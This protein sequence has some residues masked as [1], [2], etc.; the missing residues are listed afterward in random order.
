MA[1]GLNRVELI[2]NVGREPEIRYTKDGKEIASFSLATTDVW[3]DK[4]SGEKKEKTEW[5]RIAVFYEGLV[6]LV[7]NY[8]HKGTRLYIN[9]SLHTRKWTDPN[10]IEKQSSE[11]VLQ[12]QSAVLILLDTKPNSPRSEDGGSHHGEE[13]FN[14]KDSDIP[15]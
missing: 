3:T 11:I 13:S 5:H 7:K 15:F 8:V 2:G 9:G 14:N 4:A 1:V 12:N 6:T 10:G